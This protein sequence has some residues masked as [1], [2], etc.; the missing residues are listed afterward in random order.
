MFL[1]FLKCNFFLTSLCSSMY[2]CKFGQKIHTYH[3]PLLFWMYIRFHS[4][5]FNLL[6]TMI[7][8]YIHTSI[9]LHFLHTIFIGKGNVLHKL[10]RF[11]LC[12]FFGLKLTKIFTKSFFSQFLL[13]ASKQTNFRAS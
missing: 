3:F 5:C 4:Y 10:F 8:D 9:F 6:P 7:N 11:F 12:F 1:L 13:V 2:I